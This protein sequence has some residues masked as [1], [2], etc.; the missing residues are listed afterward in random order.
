MARPAIAIALPRDERAPVAEAL[1]AAGFDV[2]DIQ[3]PEDL[4]AQLAGGRE[5]GVAILDGEGDLDTS[6]EYYGLL[7]EGGRTVP[8]LMVLSPRALERFSAGHAS[9]TDEFLTRPY[10]VDAIRWRVEA[11]MIRRM[12]VDDG[13]GAIIQTGT[14]SLD[15]WSRNGTFIAVFNPK[16]G[17]GKTT[18]S[19]NLAAALTEMG[20]RVLLVDADAVTGHIAT[21]LGLERV[22]TLVDEIVDARDAGVEPASTIDDLVAAHPSGL[23]VLV[24]TA[25]PMKT[26]LLDPALVA[27]AIDSG[28]RSHDVVVV[29]LHPDYDALNRAIFEHAD[30]ILVPVTPDVPALRAAVQLRDVAGDLGFADK[31]AVIVNR[32]N[33]GVSVADMEQALGMPALALVRSAGLQLVKAANEG[34]SVIDLFPREKISEDFRILAERVVG[35]PRARKPP[36]RLSLS[37][38]FGRAREAARA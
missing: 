1:R 9:G 16:G 21:S 18:I 24:L 36:A 15:D 7:H 4:E 11:M 25:S 2:L 31:L 6:L 13:S 34:R 22:R 37:A 8:A 20:R 33:S 19:V 32:A 30:R 28:R 26:S 38:L 27:A 12:T 5:I 17:V 3:R 14:M 35:V 23:N 10:S 29:D